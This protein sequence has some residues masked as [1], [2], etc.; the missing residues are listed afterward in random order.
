M[1][2][3]MNNLISV[4]V[5]CYNHE[6]YIE[7]CLRSVFNQT[8]T[9]IELIVLDDGSTDSSP[10]IIQEVLKDSPFD[11]K[12]ETHENLGVVNN[13]NL[14]LELIRGDYLLFVDSDNYLDADY[15]EQLYSQLTETNADIAYCDL[16][17]PEK[18]EF[19]LKSRE[20]DLT[21]FLNAS[22]IDNCSLIR[23]SII[24]NTRY[25]EKLN[26]K[27]L[28]DYDFLLNLIINNGAKAIY[29]PSTK[30][31][32]RVF[33]TGSI[34]G[35]DSVRYHY[36]IYLDILEKYLDKLP[37]EVYKAVCDNLM[38]LEERLDSLLKHHDEVT[39]YVNRL[40]K[41][42]DQLERRKYTQSKRLKDAHKEM[43]LIR[44]SLSYR[45]GN[46]LITPIKTAGVIAKNPKAIKN[47]L[48]A[49]KVK[50]IQ[51]RRRMTPLKV[52]Q[53]R[54]LRNSQRSALFLASLGS[55]GR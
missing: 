42:R 48:R 34:S 46:A 3:K 53:L 21:A 15:V 50:V 28:E 29:Q 8:Y 45:L 27:K 26:R 14:G 22:F 24:G 7:Q 20:F 33:E 32:Y 55:I 36:E 38:V 52:R 43:E 10:Q 17:N 25:D 12:F 31:N 35:R 44:G 23:R 51:I 54:S 1:D 11:T 49:L 13:R 2:G 30:L 18:E 5:T 4:V 37:H 19:Y 47:Y 40:K 9:N 6:K 41:E 39:D 16:F